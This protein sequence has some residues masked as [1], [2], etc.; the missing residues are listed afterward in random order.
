VAPEPTRAT[1]LITFVSGFRDD[2]TKPGYG[3]SWRWMMGRAVMRV[4]LQRQGSEWVDAG[5][6]YSM[7]ALDEEAPWVEPTGCHNSVTRGGV[8]RPPGPLIVNNG[9]AVRLGIDLAA[10][11]AELWVSGFS[12]PGLP[13]HA[14]ERGSQCYNPGPWRRTDPPD[15][16][17]AVGANCAKGRLDGTGREI[18]FRGDDCA[19]TGTSQSGT[20]KTFHGS[21][22]EGRIRLIP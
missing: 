16:G 1:G 4:R 22:L 19:S 2:D 7:V 17:W 10:G 20:V 6:T 14:G 15:A 13:Q 21:R 11:T 3:P 12:A 9:D 18:E 5:S 8:S